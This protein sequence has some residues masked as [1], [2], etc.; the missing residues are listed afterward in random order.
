MEAIVSEAAHR[1]EKYIP[2]MDEFLQIRRSTVAVRVA[3][4]IS[5]VDIELPDDVRNHPTLLHMELAINDAC[6]AAN[7]LVFSSCRLSNLL[8]HPTSLGSVLI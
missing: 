8:I 3:L 1:G 2:R 5:Q 4:A 6:L 7:V